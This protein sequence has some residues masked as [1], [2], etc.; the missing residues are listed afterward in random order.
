M[1]KFEFNPFTT[2]D[3]DA[4]EGDAKR[5]ALERGAEYLREQVVRYM[6][7]QNSPVAGHGAFK[8]LSKDYAERKKAEGGTPVPNLELHGDLKDAIQTY[9]SG[10]KIGIKVTGKQGK[11]ADGHCNLSGDSELP[12]R[13][14]I[15]DE[16]EM[17]KSTIMAGIGRIIR[18]S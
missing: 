1:V 3:I 11:V 18:S 15:P 6:G 12:M 10:N 16:D 5:E 4:P 9:V 14:F 8:A 7:N 17:W 13:R 2:L